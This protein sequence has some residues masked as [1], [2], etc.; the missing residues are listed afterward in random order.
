MF[1]KLKRKIKE[2]IK[3]AEVDEIARRYFAIN[4]FDGVLTILGIIIASYFAGVSEI[5]IVIAACVG[6]AIAIG[7]SGFYGVWL[8][9]TA[10]RNKI[11]KELGRKIGMGFEKSEIAKA[12]RFAVYFLAFIDGASPVVAALMI[13]GPFF[14]SALAVNMMYYAAICIS[15]AI[16]FALGLFLGKISKENLIFSGIRVLVIGFVCILIIKLVGGI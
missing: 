13:I 16:L 14:F 15:F 9:E 8:T 7:V 10:E 12:H 11:V 1:E 5:K 2:Y 3:I 6:A 4:T